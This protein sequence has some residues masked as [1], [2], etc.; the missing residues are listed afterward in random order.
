VKNLVKDDF[1]VVSGLARGVD[2][3]AHR[4][5]LAAGGRNS[6]PPCQSTNLACSKKVGAPPFEPLA[7]ER[8]KGEPW[9]NSCRPS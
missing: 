3:E 9:P 8:E 2:T 6:L 1:T 4:T 5:T 7:N